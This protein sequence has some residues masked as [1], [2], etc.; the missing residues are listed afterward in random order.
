M[1]PP[2][3]VRALVVRGLVQSLVGGREWAGGAMINGRACVSDGRVVRRQDL[4]LERT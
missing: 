4:E 1:G 3:Q 2:D